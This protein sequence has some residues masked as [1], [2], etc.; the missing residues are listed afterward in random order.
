MA[1]SKTENLNAKTRYRGISYTT[2]S[3]ANTSK[4]V[5]QEML[6]YMQSILSSGDTAD[7]YI[8]Q[9][10]YDSYG[11]IAL[12]TNQYI[13]KLMMFS[14]NTIYTGYNDSRGGEQICNYTGTTL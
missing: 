12:K 6:A 9:P 10:G 3:S 13:V 14:V 4:K 5:M 2:S 8:L 1:T 7:G 11:F